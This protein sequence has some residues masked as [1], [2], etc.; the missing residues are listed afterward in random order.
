VKQQYIA[1]SD[2]IPRLMYGLVCQGCDYTKNWKLGPDSLLAH[3]VVIARQTGWV[4]LEVNGG[5]RTFCPECAAVARK[6][7]DALA[8]A[9]VAFWLEDG[10]TH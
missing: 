10:G 2:L 5:M 9:D 1:A 6:Q 3:V 7:G 4:R 8:E